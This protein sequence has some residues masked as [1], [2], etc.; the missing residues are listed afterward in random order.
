MD[1]VDDFNIEQKDYFTFNFLGKELVLN[2]HNFYKNSMDIIKFLRNSQY[3]C[4][5]NF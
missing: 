3:F 5:I 2:V 4:N 1:Y